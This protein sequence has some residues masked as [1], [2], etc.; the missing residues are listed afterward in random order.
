MIKKPWEWKRKLFAEIELRLDAAIDKLDNLSKN[1][2]FNKMMK[3]GLETVAGDI[4]SHGQIPMV[5]EKIEYQ[6]GSEVFDVFQKLEV[7][8]E[9]GGQLLDTIMKKDNIRR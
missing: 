2:E 7:N 5:A 3:H 1:V 8:K 9:D 6:Y 4:I